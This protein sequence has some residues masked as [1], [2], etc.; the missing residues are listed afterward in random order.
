MQGALLTLDALEAAYSALLRATM[1]RQWV[2]A[3]AGVPQ[4]LP[5]DRLALNMAISLLYTCCTRVGMPS[6]TFRDSKM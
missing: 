2:A 6:F 1:E 5:N 3:A 4:P